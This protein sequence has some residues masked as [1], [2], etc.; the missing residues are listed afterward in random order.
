MIGEKVKRL[1]KASGMYQ[2]ELA[3]AAGIS[4]P[5]LIKIEKNIHVRKIRKIWID[6]IEKVFNL[7]EGELYDLITPPKVDF[8]IK[9]D[10]PTPEEI[11]TVRIAKG[12]SQFELSQLSGIN[13][14]SVCNI[15]RGRTVSDRLLKTMGAAL[16]LCDKPIEKK[17]E[18]IS[19]KKDI[20][21]ACYDLEGNLLETV[22]GASYADVAVQLGMSPQSVLDCLKN[23][24]RQ[25]GGFQLRYVSEDN[26]VWD[27]IGDITNATRRQDPFLKIYKGRVIAMYDS[28]EEAEKK[29]KVSA[30]SISRCLSGEIQKAGKY[31]WVKA[32]EIFKKPIDGS[33]LVS[34]EELKKLKSLGIDLE[35]ILKNEKH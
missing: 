29:S 7:E 19:E 35:K 17:Q 24:I 10:I 4:V 11:R 14:T 26:P 22:N 9:G 18:D 33:I 31:D 21:V 34:Q 6:K 5:T 23:R 13:Q 12:M 20:R 15:E 8:K 25:S 28:L 2:K 27:T 32:S 3:E 30:G 16:G 1:R